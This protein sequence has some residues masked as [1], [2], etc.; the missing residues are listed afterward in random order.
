[1]A[2][3]VE[4][5]RCLRS[6]LLFRGIHVVVAGASGPKRRDLRAEPHLEVVVGRLLCELSRILVRYER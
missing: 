4:R 6:R 5:D 1:M 3:L 2:Q